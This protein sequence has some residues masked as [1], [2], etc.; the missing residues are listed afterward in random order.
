MNTIKL[1]C[2]SLMLLVSSSLLAKDSAQ[3][4]IRLSVQLWSV[5]DQLKNDFRGTIKQLAD[6]GFQGVELAGFYGDF[7]EDPEGLA[8]FIQSHGMQI[9]GTHSNFNLLSD[10]KFDQTIDF[11]KRA[12]VK[13]V[14]IAWDDRA[15]DANTVWKTIAD[16][17]R[18]HAK[19]ESHGLRFGYHNHAEEFGAYRDVTLW[20][21]IARSTPDSLV[22]QLDVGWVNHAGLNPSDFVRRYPGRTLS[23]HFKAAENETHKGKLPIIGQDSANW[24]ELIKAT[25]EVGGTQWIV[26]EQEEY[27]NGL[28]QLQAVEMSKKGLD[29][30]LNSTK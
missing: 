5:K 11:Y 26:L 6:M 8:K 10:E 28:T 7:N 25:R 17:N 30:F 12:G 14:V 1:F 9:S 3:Q 4:D 13:T 16:L 19:L 22:L 2:I 21:H 20:D 29:K 15:F 24:P 18:L 23:T 27:P